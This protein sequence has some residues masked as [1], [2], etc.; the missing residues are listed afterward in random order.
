MDITPLSTAVSIAPLR[1]VQKLLDC[2]A[3]DTVFRGQLLHFA[4]RRTDDDCVAVVELVLRR[5]QARVNAMMWED[6]PLSYE[7]Y[8]LTGLGTPLH[9]VAREG[10]PV[11]AE[12]LLREGADIHRRDSCGK[13]ALERAEIVRNDAVA[14]LLRNAKQKYIA[15]AESKI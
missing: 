11:I 15:C 9:E 14:E 1:V 12:I 8:K 3:N 5:C 7:C 13:T 10:L 2:C 4:A 6:Q